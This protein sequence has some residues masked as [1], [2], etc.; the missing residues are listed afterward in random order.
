[1]V[2]GRHPRD[3][4]R[5]GVFEVDVRAGE[6]R[7][8]GLRIKLQEQP[9]RI[10]TLLLE[11]P[12][13]V[14]TRDDLQKQLWVADT[15]VDFDSG[16]NKAINR[17]REALADS[18]ENPRFI[19]TLPKRGYRFIAHVE[20][21]GN[22]NGDSDTKATSMQDRPLPE[23]V[24]ISSLT[25][26]RISLSVALILLTI[27]VFGGIAWWRSGRQ[28][29]QPVRS[30]LL[31]PANTSFLPSNFA[32]SPDG[33]RL[34]FVASGPDGN[35]MLYV[36]QLS[37]AGSQELNGTEGARFPFWSWD[38]RQIAFFAAGKL[39]TLD[40]SSGVV[41]TLCDAPAGM[42]GTW[43]RDGAIVFA[44]NIAGPLYQISLEAQRVRRAPPDLSGTVSRRT[45]FCASSIEGGIAA[46][47]APTPLKGSGQNQILPW[48]LPDGNH[49]LYAVVHSAPADPL[50][51]GIY[52]GS[53]SSTTTKLVSS[54]L[55]GKVAFAS[56]RILYVHEG[57]LVAQPFDPERLK[58][59]GSPSTIAEQELDP[60]PGF[61]GSTFSVSQ[62]GA[63]VFQ[64]SA[65]SVS[66]LLWF[67]NFG[68]PLDPLPGA[69]FKDP[70]LSPDGRLLAISSDD[71]RNGKRYIGAFDLARGV[72]RRLTDGRSDQSPVWSR[73]G[74]EIAYASK[75]GNFTYV[76]SVPADGSHPP[77]VLLKD[78]NIAPYGWTPGGDLLLGRLN[79]GI[80]DIAVYSAVSRQIKHLATGVE[81]QLSPDGKWIA[82]IWRGVRA[83]PFPGPG[84]YIQISDRSGAQP[85]WSRDGKQL[86]YVTPDKK[87][88]SVD[89]D[90]S[91]GIAGA[92]R[93]LFQTNIVAPNYAGFQYDVASEN[94]FLI[95]S[96]PSGNWSPLTL[97]TGWAGRD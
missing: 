20:H 8:S 59:I 2:D 78:L 82:Y 81:A 51:D 55:A 80:P 84:A 19:E 61:F 33:A 69:G 50:R 7:K 23:P 21:A 66:R 6:L 63:L 32:I 48:F 65:D 87:I 60:D 54:E 94:R 25:T 44:P 30:S 90:P 1:M 5:F 26:N 4:I 76:N 64:S 40:P 52:A 11:R 22:G 68:K 72:T 18:A 95:N 93:E 88:M 15:F 49:F 42:G 77:Q 29:L 37:S 85:R 28:P 57:S 83:Q 47:V 17:L 79:D 71:A 56:G 34:T 96:L 9:F 27:A 38:S 46:P 36:R 13:Q 43:N 53:L 97:I 41:R 75:D 3:V 70:S 91:R 12:G 10:L 35:V 39:K 89:F 45:P 16:L 67:D 31:P 58:M 73:D 14:V 62:T 24:S 74:K 92:P 86:F